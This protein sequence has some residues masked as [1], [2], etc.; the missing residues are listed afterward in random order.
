MRELDSDQSDL[1]HMVEAFF[2][3]AFNLELLQD[4][5]YVTVL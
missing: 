1:L 3:Q 5:Y 2:S 4:S